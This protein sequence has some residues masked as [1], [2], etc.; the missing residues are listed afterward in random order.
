M[1]IFLASSVLSFYIMISN[2]KY[3]DT[4]TKPLYPVIAIGFITLSISTL[5]MDM[6]GQSAD[7]LILAY[8]TDCE[9]ERYHF[10][11]D[12]CGSCPEQIR[13]TITHIRK[14]KS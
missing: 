4:I 9:V 11:R 5:F 7:G 13:E 8:F 10:G 2:P 6:F 12:E 1:F 14:K 3:N